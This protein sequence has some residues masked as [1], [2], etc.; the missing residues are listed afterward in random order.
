[1][2]YAGFSTYRHYLKASW[3]RYFKLSREQLEQLMAA[4][5]QA[6]DGPP[7]T[8]DELAAAVVSLTGEPGL[9]ERLAD[10]WGAVLKP[11]SFRGH[12]CF[13]PNRGQN[14][15]FTRPDQ[16][17]S[18]WRK[19]NPEHALEEVTRRFLAA[20]GPATRED[21]A[22]WWAVTPAG[23]GA[24][25]ARLGDDVAQV[26]VEGSAAVM[27][28]ADLELA[29]DAPPR[30]VRLVPAFDQ[31]V[32]GATRHAAQLGA[33]GLLDRIYRPQGWLS[34]VLLVGGR[35]GGVWR[36]ELKGKRL[37]V[38]VEPF[39]KLPAWARRGAAEE[40]ERLAAFLGG[41]LELEVG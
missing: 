20:N 30:S 41:E 27:L 12:L 40:A 33:A 16:W 17:L 28:A 15:R 7:L 5:A 25:I 29:G 1:V 9:G 24:Q 11:A 8:R 3:F 6:L 21:L 22:R 35:M 18:G 10:S 36:H 2:G 37:L 23:G 31:Y 4:V 13:A 26:D 19:E 32:V 39:T 14:V 34:P 38:R